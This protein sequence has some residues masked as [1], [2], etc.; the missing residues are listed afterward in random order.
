MALSLYAVQQAFGRRWFSRTMPEASPASRHAGTAAPPSRPRRIVLYSH[1]T[2]GL[3]H[4]RRNLMIA[5]ALLKRDPQPAILMIGGA[6]EMGKLR[7]PPG[8]DCLTLPALGKRSDG[9]YHPRWLPVSLR[10]L[11]ALRAATIQ[12]A[13]EAFEPDALIVDKVPLGA[14]NELE[15][16]LAWLRERGT[17]RCVLGLREVLD[18]PHTARR[19]WQQSGSDAAIRAYY[20]A[21]WVYGDRT[22]Y[23]P[24]QE[25]GFSRD[26]ADK[27]CYTGYLDRSLG[28]DEAD[29]DA[30]HLLETLDL[31]ADRRMALCC[32][33]GGQDG[34]ALAAA[35]AQAELPAD[36]VGVIVTGPFMS[37]ESQQRL[38]QI[39]ADS[40]RLRIVHFVEE[41]APLL[42]RADAVV[43]MGGY[44]TVCEVLAFEKRALIVPRV[45]PRREQLIRAERLRDRGVIDLLHPQLLTP[46]AI[47]DWLAQ[48]SGGHLNI[49]ERIDM[50]ALQRLPD[51]LDTLCAHAPQPLEVRYATA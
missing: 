32:V 15:P 14:F 29:R 5:K 40:R 51:L 10:R 18:D 49:R 22:V 48:P 6:R 44:N 11:I 9:Q 3:G 34:Y 28:T 42:R 8:V 24:V 25:Y 2:Q 47:A 26:V 12:S 30:E 17:T 41:T 23:D 38:Q 43:C 46:R 7:L 39:A 20:D 1:D 16:S 27:L 50:N 4:M 37:P 45:K 33:G 13:I 19:E 31:P 21:I 35:F 36:M